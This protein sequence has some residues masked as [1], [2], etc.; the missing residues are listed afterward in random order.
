MHC[1][2]VFA[3]D[4]RR[5]ALSPLQQPSSP[6]AVVSPLATPYTY[7]LQIPQPA[8]DSGNIMGRIV[9][10]SPTARIFLAG[11][12]Y[13]GDVIHSK[14]EVSIPFVSVLVGIVP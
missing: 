1:G 7:T 9:A 6:L 2:A 14:G 10:G 13:L 3:Y 11:D 4:P 5:A 8:S 12:I